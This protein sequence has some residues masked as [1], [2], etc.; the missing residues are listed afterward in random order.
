[1]LPKSVASACH[2]HE[3]DVVLNGNRLPMRQNH[4]QSTSHAATNKD[5]IMT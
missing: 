5:A 3:M 4:K 2:A 1:M